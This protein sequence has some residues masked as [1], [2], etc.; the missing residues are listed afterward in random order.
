MKFSALGCLL[1]LASMSGCVRVELG[2]QRPTLG[3]E[4]RDLVE[5]RE[6]G[7]LDD[8]EYMTLKHKLLRRLLD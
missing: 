2:E 3:E 6:D 5:A 4:I 1:V 8:D 7:Y